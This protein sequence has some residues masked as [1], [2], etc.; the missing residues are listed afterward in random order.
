MIHTHTVAE[1]E[2]WIARLLLVYGLTLG[3]LFLA[4]WW[5]HVD[6]RKRWTLPALDVGG[7]VAAFVSVYA[8]ILVNVLFWPTP[9]HQADIVTT[10]ALL[11]MFLITV[12]TAITIRMLHWRR[13]RRST[14][15]GEP[16]RRRTEI[17]ENPL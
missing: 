8:V 17:M 7:W 4:S 14:G 1:V 2:L 9:N 6:P 12:D 3:V 10:R 11:I 5:P 15:D 16:H 13:I